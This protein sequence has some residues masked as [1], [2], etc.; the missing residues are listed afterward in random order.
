MIF[1]GREAVL[2]LLLLLVVGA[3][4]PRVVMIDGRLAKREATSMSCLI[5]INI[6]AHKISI[7]KTSS[8]N[9]HNLTSMLQHCCKIKS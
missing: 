2:P 6:A 8:I 4:W 3:R 5:I 7:P 1:I 9:L